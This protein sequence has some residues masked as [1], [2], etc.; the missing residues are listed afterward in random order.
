M[1]II[2][3]R[4]SIE[5]FLHKVKQ[6]KA[7]WKELNNPF[8]P[9]FYPNIDQIDKFEAKIPS[10]LK[11]ALKEYVSEQ[12]QDRIFGDDENQ[13]DIKSIKIGLQELAYQ[14]VKWFLGKKNHKSYQSLADSINLMVVAAA[15]NDLWKSLPMRK[16]FSIPVFQTETIANLFDVFETDPQILSGREEFSTLSP[17]T[18]QDYPSLCQT[19]LE[20]YLTEIAKKEN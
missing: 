16:G 12:D 10:F 1:R 13:K 19:F 3:A 20:E 8:F 6:W 14:I 17:N 15:W 11:E 4:A 7:L 9:G 18:W 5:G 2:K